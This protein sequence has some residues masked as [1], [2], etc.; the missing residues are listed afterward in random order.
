MRLSFKYDVR[1]INNI[2][3]EIINDLMWHM[4]KVYNILLHKLREKEKYIDA[5]KSVNIISDRKSVV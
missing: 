3:K 2:Q 4:T 1:N 5:N